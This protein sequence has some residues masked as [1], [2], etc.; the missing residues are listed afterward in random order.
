MR[1]RNFYIFVCAASICVWCSGAHAGPARQKPV[2][3]PFLKAPAGKV[4]GCD[5]EFRHGYDVVI[6][7]AEDFI[8]FLKSHQSG[9]ELQGFSPSEAGLVPGYTLQSVGKEER[10]RI[11][12]DDL[13]DKVKVLEV[14]KSASANTRIFILQISHD[15]Y[16]EGWPW[17]LLITASNHGQVSVVYCPG[18]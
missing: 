15:D 2:D 16:D 11:S 17:Q 4:S 12:L 18:K 5:R 14:K 1:K 13:K 6:A 10:K 9:E 8:A 7:T 3:D